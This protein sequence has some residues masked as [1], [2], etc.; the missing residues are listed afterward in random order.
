MGLLIIGNNLIPPPEGMKMTAES[1][2]AH[3]HLFEFKHYIVPF[4][5]RA[6]GTLVGA[7]IV[8][9]MGRSHHQNLAMFIGAF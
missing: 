5:A 6:G 4:I 9:I 3:L 1:I 2:R 7:F 8:A